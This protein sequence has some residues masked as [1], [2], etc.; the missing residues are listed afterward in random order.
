MKE[1]LYSTKADIWALG[2]FMLEMITGNLP[3]SK[4]KESELKEVI[5]NTNFES[6]LPN[7]LDLQWKIIILKCL[8]VNPL[9][10][11]GAIEMMKMINPDY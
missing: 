6:L 7:S 8:E 4:N 1:N 11:C 5:M 2:V 10:R 3:W 9:K